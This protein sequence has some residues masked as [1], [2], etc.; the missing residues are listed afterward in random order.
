MAVAA[1]AALAAGM[2]F[3]QTAAA[4]KP[5]QDGIDLRAVRQRILASLSLT[6]AQKAQAK[7]IRQQAQTAAQPLRQELQQNRQALTAAIQS[8]DAAQITRL[9]AAQGVLQG[10]IVAIRATARANFYAILT[11]AQQTTLTQAEGKL[12]QLLKQLKA[13]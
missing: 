10:Q 2:A 7:T 12:Q 5:A 3:A 6:D 9:A 4:P 13:L 1:V 8:N 11:P